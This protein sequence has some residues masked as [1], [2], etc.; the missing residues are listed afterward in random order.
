VSVTLGAEDLEAPD[1]AE[2]FSLALRTVLLTAA[3]GDTVPGRWLQVES[4]PE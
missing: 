3:C 4:L 2:R 1:A